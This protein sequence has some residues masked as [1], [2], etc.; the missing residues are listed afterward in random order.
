M[1]GIQKKLTEILET[2]SFLN[3]IKYSKKPLQQT[4]T[5]RRPHFKN[6]RKKKYIYIKQK[7]S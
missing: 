6:Q 2:K 5:S 3:Q 7:N 1:H 4:G